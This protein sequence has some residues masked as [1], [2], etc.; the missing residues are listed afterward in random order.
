MPFAASERPALGASLL[1]AHLRRRGVR[2]DVA[3]LNLLFAE[4]LGRAYYERLVDALP[5]RAMTGEWV[6]AEA[7]WE[8][9]PAASAAYVDDV[10]RGRW[11][12]SPEDV[13]LVLA[14]R[15]AAAGFL[16]EA[17]TSIP[18]GEYGLVGF[19]SYTSQNL[20]SIA[21][22]RV[23]KTAHPDVRIAFGGAN[24][25][26]V[27]GVQLHRRLHVV[28]FACSGEA[29]VS[30]PLLVD[31]LLGSTEVS[32]DRIPGLV[33]RQGGRTRWN[34]EGEPIVDLDALPTPDFSDFYAWRHRLP[35]VRTALPSLVLEASRGCWWAEK[36]PCR[37]C[38][39]DDHER[40]YRSKSAGRVLQEI[41]EVAEEWPAATIHMA[42]TVV[43]PDFLESVVPALAGDPRIPRLFL[44]VR[45]ELTPGRLKDLAAARALIQP[46]IESFSD[47]LLGLLHKGSRALENI[48]LL[49]RCRSLDL[50]V[51][52]N[53]LY[54]VPGETQRDYDDMLALFPAIRFLAPPRHC[55]SVSVDR[56]SPY[57]EEP[58]RHGI[59]TLKPLL[60][61]RYLYPFDEA[62]LADIAYTFEP[63][64]DEAGAAPDVGAVLGEEAARWER[65]AP[66]GDLRVG[67]RERGR[68]TL[69]D[70]RP[71]AARRVIELDALDSL[72]YGACD[73]I[74]TVEGLVAIARAA[75]PALVHAEES[76]RGRL[77]R[78]VEERLMVRVGDRFLS[79]ALVE[80]AV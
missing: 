73:D 52:W 48:R 31:W 76:V 44:E 21:L 25:Q 7:A 80:S 28:D 11:H 78:M 39:M 53:L 66:L 2:C 54:G 59:R 57:F 23:V 1:K 67:G 16:H 40:H 77:D 45:P 74:A 12:A 24:W 68:V 42:D 27:S 5:F 19:S 65:E 38:G 37:F 32:L 14:A 3:Y 13:E 6:F 43:P 29:D 50:E 41:R 4:R 69:I 46:G 51:H 62:V 9:P 35:G 63:V 22:A 64:C 58:E 34:A 10:L 75:H 36:G 18:W 60:P 30:F 70:K 72:L 26:G 79:L 71:G 8:R 56:Y 49:K 17:L 55:Q 33:Y 61:Y 20:A 15:R 47:H